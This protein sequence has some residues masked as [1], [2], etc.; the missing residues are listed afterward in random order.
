MGKAERRCRLYC[1]L[2]GVSGGPR[3][4]ETPEATYFSKSRT[5]LRQVAHR[6][7]SFPALQRREAEVGKTKYW[8]V[9]ETP[10]NLAPSPVCLLG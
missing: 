3:R 2:M 6:W 5:H 8:V 9:G 10:P 7:R 4:G 1:I